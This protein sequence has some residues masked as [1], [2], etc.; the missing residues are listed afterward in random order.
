[1]SDTP[2]FICSVCDYEYP[3]DRRQ[4]DMTDHVCIDCAS[5]IISG[6]E[7]HDDSEADLGEPIA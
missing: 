4:P 1:M 5:V 2:T 3:M 6:V 7:V